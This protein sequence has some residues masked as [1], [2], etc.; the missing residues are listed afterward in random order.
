MRVSD[1]N[2]VNNIQL[3]IQ[4]LKEK[5]AEQKNEIDELNNQLEMLDNSNKEVKKLYSKSLVIA[6][7]DIVTDKDSN[8]KSE[9]DI[10]LI[11]STNLKSSISL[12]RIE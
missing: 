7:D 1:D 9:E 12:Y 4:A 8:K 2:E 3:Q 5:L 10:K 11:Q 6:L